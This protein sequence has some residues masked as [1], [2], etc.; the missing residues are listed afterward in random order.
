VVVRYAPTIAYETCRD[1]SGP[2]VVPARVVP[3]PHRY[4]DGTVARPTNLPRRLECA[5]AAGA[6]ATRVVAAVTAG[7][8]TVQ[9][10]AGTSG[11]VGRTCSVCV[12][13]GA[14]PATFA[15]EIAQPAG[16]PSDLDLYERPDPDCTA[17]KIAP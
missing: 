7:T 9:D 14:Q 5:L 13:R 12:R 15:L 1:A 2:V 3:D 11:P 4:G 17:I 6:G 16:T 10:G 8:V